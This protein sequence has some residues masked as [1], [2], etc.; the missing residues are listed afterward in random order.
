M[1]KFVKKIS[2]GET[3]KALEIGKETYFEQKPFRPALIS[4]A[5]QRLKKHGYDFYCAEAGLPSGIKVTRIK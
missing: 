2:L 1:A 3:L 5:A 4:A